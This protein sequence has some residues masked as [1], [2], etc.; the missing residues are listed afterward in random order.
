MSTYVLFMERGCWK[1]VRRAL[2]ELGH[3]VLTPTLTGVADRVHLL[4]PQVDLET[5]ISDVV[6]LIRWEKLSDVV[7]RPFLRRLRD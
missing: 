7:L 2:Q 3:E 5:H 6:N 1:H 4:S